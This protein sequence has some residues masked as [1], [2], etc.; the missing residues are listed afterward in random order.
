MNSA[1]LHYADE[2]C[3]NISSQCFWF[4]CLFK[5]VTTTPMRNVSFSH[6]QRFT[7]ISAE[8]VSEI[9]IW[10]SRRNIWNTAFQTSLLMSWSC[11]DT[12]CRH[13]R[14]CKH[15]DMKGRKRNFRLI[16]WMRWDRWYY[17]GW[18]SVGRAA[19]SFQV[20]LFFVGE[21]C[22]YRC[23]LPGGEW[24]GSLHLHTPT[25]ASCLHELH[26]PDQ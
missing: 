16:W 7:S 20:H 21:S 25:S 14:R 11:I 19:A 4:L 23:L 9:W 1:F 5:Y 26:T 10:P 18:V 8:N 6:T 13:G 15:T 12:A 2:Q 3:N 17:L 22:N 24:Q